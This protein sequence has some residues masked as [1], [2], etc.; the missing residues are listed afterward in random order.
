MPSYRPGTKWCTSCRQDADKTFSSKE[1]F[2][3]PKK[4]KRVGGNNTII[5]LT[6]FCRSCCLM[7]KVKAKSNFNFL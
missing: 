2:Q 1:E 4:K 7:T 5:Y 6:T 3:T